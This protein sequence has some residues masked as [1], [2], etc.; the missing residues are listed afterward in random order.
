MRSFIAKPAVAPLLAL[1]CALVGCKSAPPPPP[2]LKPPKISMSVTVGADVNPD[3]NG[4]AAP[5]VVRIY[6]LKDD[7]A[8]TA[9]DFF[10]LYDKEQMTLGPALIERR[11]FELAPGEQ[12]SFDYPVPNDARFIGAIAAFRDIRNAQWRAVAPAPKQEPQKEAKKI[13]LAVAVERLKITL[14]TM[15]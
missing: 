14:S 7:A 3:L 8:F 13:P 2:P 10:A 1:M 6:Q 15:N 9:A 11:E 4:K 5:V 12:R